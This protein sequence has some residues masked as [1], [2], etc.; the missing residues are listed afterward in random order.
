MGLGGGDLRVLSNLT[1][2]NFL[3]LPFWGSQVSLHETVLSC[4]QFDQV[5]KIVE[6]LGIPPDHILH[7][8]SRTEKFFEKGAGGNW[9]LR[10]FRDNR[11]VRWSTYS[12]FHLHV[13][14]PWRVVPFWSG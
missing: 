10:R 8:A 13:K 1:F 7:M 3:C 6:V 2:C 4:M 9:M 14:F 5:G 12:S 11:K